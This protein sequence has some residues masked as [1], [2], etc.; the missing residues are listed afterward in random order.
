[1]VVAQ[2]HGHRGELVKDVGRDKVVVVDVRVGLRLRRGHHRSAGS[3]WCERASEIKGGTEV[4][5]ELRYHPR[6]LVQS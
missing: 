1:M 4:E 5:R 6:W 2:L 3:P